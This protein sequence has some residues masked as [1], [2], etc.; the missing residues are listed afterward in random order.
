MNAVEKPFIFN[1]SSYSDTAFWHARMGILRR[2]AGAGEAGACKRCRKKLRVAE[3][4]H[5][6]WEYALGRRLIEDRFQPSNEVTRLEYLNL[7]CSHA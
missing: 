6:G 1:G 4:F 7:E 2:A 5:G 3:T